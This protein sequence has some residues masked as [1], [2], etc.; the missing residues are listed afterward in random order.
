[1]TDIG[2]LKH[3][4]I[5][6][7]VVLLTQAEFRKFRVPNLLSD[8]EDAGFVVFHFP[9]GNK[10][11]F[12]FFGRN[13]NTFFSDDGMVPEDVLGLISLVEKIRK[14]VADGN[15]VLVHCYGGLGRAVLVGA[16]LLQNIDEDISPDEVIAQL[17][18]LRGPRAVQSVKQYNF[19]NEYRDLCHKALN[20]ASE[21]EGCISR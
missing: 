1:M 3:L 18:E 17:R 19:I 8:Y 9:I 21:D 11:I 20:W 6:D 12:K 10:K 2:S 7:I 5:S 15:R 4:D 14:R 13:Q 16:C